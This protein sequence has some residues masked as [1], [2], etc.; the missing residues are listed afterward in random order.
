MAPTRP[1][2]RPAAP[3]TVST[4]NRCRHL[5]ARL[6]LH[7]ATLWAVVPFL[8][9][10]VFASGLA[11]LVSTL[12]LYLRDTRSFLPYVMRVWLYLSPV[13][14]LPEQIRHGFA[15]VRWANPLFPLVGAWSDAVVEGVRPSMTMLVTGAAW[16]VGALV[17]GAWALLSREREFAVRL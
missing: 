3:L 16:A 8:L 10:V 4:F 13:L 15:F 9:V 17:V 14:W 7:L 1:D 12:T 6:P 5:V 11:M 2:Q